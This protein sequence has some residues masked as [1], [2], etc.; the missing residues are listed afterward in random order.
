M[1]IE[2]RARV[3]RICINFQLGFQ[4]I[5]YLKSSCTYSQG[6][7]EGREENL[8]GL[9]QEPA[10]RQKESL[11]KASLIEKTAPD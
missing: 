6:V 3:C 8:N 1:R 9:A 10:Q 11:C 4:D 7:K 5:K 2:G